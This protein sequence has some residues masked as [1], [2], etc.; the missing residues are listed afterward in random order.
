MMPKS[1]KFVLTA[2]L[3]M[4][5]IDILTVTVKNNVDCYQNV[6]LAMS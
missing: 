3:Y 2:S 4:H 5:S 6:F 1:F